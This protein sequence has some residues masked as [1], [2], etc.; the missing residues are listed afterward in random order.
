LDKNIMRL[1]IGKWGNSL[2]VRLPATLLLKLF[3]KEGDTLEVAIE[4]DGTLHLFP[5][6]GFNKK[7]F[8]TKLKKLHHSLPHTE[9][10]IEVMRK[11]QRY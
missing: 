7:G 5:S 9:S 8:L 2:A 10:V 11:E 4:P 3:L 6:H 1:Q